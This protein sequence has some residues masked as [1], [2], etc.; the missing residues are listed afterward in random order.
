[1]VDRKDKW[2]LEL[3]EF[4]IV[5][6]FYLSL[7]LKEIPFIGAIETKINLFFYL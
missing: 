1:M 3:Y 2:E 6:C 4:L 5:K 7:L